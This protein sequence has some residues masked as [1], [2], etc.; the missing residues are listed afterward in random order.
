M[1][2]NISLLRSSEIAVITM[3]Y[4]YF[5]PNGVKKTRPVG[6]KYL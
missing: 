3:S 6:T 5:T 2:F 1:A 4:K